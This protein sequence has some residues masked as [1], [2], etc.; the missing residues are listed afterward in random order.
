[1]YIIAQCR[2]LL[3]ITGNNNSRIIIIFFFFNHDF[4]I[5]NN[6]SDNKND[7]YNMKNITNKDNFLKEK[8][9]IIVRN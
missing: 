3:Q 9:N 4:I 8:Q 2:H 6:K 7:R 5:L 1:M